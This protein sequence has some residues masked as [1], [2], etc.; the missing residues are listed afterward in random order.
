MSGRLKESC[1]RRRHPRTPDSVYPNGDCKACAKER[2]SSWKR[3]QP[4]PCGHE[5]TSE[6][7]RLNAAGK[8]NGCAVCPV[9][10]RRRPK[11]WI[12]G[13]LRK[14]R[15]CQIEKD[16]AEFHLIKG[17]PN[18]RCKD[19][20]NVRSNAYWHS[21]SLE[22]KRAKSRKSL[23]GKFGL[24]EEDYDALLDAF[25]GKCGICGNPPEEGQALAIDH[26]HSCCPESG[27]SC[28]SCVR[29]LLCNLCNLRF[30]WVEQIGLDKILAYRDGTM[31]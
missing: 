18:S 21:L 2:S 16:L 17:R 14:C 31:L 7:T 20:H 6:N 1:G 23:L 29:G 4:F 19:C 12:A 10:P 3:N 15:D 24:T 11:Q 25:D 26:D 9:K 5:R 27:R 28:G 13:E 30:G 8:A 22:E